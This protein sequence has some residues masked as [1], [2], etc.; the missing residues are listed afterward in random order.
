MRVQKAT[1]N[2]QKF[3]SSSHCSI[4][5]SLYLHQSRSQR[6][7]SIWLATGIA[8]SGPTSFPGSLF[9][10]NEVASGPSGWVQLVGPT[11][12]SSP[13]PTIILTCGNDRELF[14]QH[15]KSAIH[16]LPVKSG[17]SD[18]L[19]IW[20]EYSAHAQKIG[21][22]QSS[23]SLPQVRKI[24]ALGTRVVQ[25]RKSAIHGLPVTL[26]MLRVKSDKCDWFWSQSIV[27]TKPF[28]TGMSLDLARVPVFPAH[29]K[30]DPW[31]WGCVYI[32]YPCGA[33]A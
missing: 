4:Y 3:N 2:R 8:T 30:R 1:K 18:W 21:S 22:G 7:R 15:R 10:G 33:A 32:C 23:R 27:F 5:P 19:R 31:G 17:K 20:N 14:V 6:P 11:P 9:S 28:K 16:A 29:D 25:L 13:E 26:R 12:F 24:V